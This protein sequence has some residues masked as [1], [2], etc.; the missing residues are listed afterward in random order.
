MEKTKINQDLIF[1]IYLM[2]STVNSSSQNLML[3][4]NIQST[5]QVNPPNYLELPL[6]I[7]PELIILD[8]HSRIF[9]MSCSEN[10]SAKILSKQRKRLSTRITSL[11]NQHFWKKFWEAK[12]S[13]V[14]TLLCWQISISLMDFNTS[15]LFIQLSRLISQV[16]LV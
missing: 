12:N 2:S 3:V 15:S 13:M 16:W 4:F 8:L 10:Y 5:K 9:R 1:P 14:E 11:Q 7:K 6:R